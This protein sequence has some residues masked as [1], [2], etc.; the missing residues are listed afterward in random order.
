M[1][2]KSILFV[3]L[4]FAL[5]IMA[6]GIQV[7]LPEVNIPVDEIQVG[8]MQTETIS[9]QAP[10]TGDAN[11]KIGFGI[12]ELTLAP[13]A[14]GLL[15]EGTASYNVVDLKPTITIE[16]DN[17]LLKT[18]DLE[19]SGFP[20]LRGANIKNEWDLKLG[21]M[22]MDL[23]IDA[24]AYKGTFELGNLSLKSLEVGDGAADVELVFSAPNRVPMSS[25]RYNTGA[26]K[27]RLSGLANANF[28]SMLFRSGAGDYRLDFS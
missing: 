14:A 17:V 12:G 2:P 13:G 15:V 27:V 8:P 7:D 23:S 5:V 22:P 3:V 10:A 6:C 20:R 11:L 19:I 24:G 4:V 28:S 18:G 25:F 1:F 16:G 26:S 9:I 21:D